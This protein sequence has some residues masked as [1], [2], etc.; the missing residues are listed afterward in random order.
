[1][2]RPSPDPKL[3][4]YHF[5]AYYLR[6]LRKKHQ[7]TQ[8]QVAEILHCSDSQISKYESGEKLLNGEECER[9]DE[10]W[11]TGKLFQIMLFFAKLGTDTSWPQRLARYQRTAIEHCVFGENVVPLPLQTEGYARSILE[12]GHAAGFLDDVD[13]ALAIRMERQRSMLEGDPEVWVI[14]DE[15][16]LRPMGPPQVMAEQ[17]DYLLEMGRQR[18]VSVRI[19]PKSAAPHIGVDGSFHVFTLRDNRR[20]AYSGNAINVGRVI[21]DQKEVASV[22]LR[23]QRLAARSLSEDQSRDL[24]AKMGEDS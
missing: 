10:T 4:L 18:N 12:A 23:F 15:V 3:S 1:M 13:I 24:I 17:R 20:A 19:L 14:I 22:A 21:D 2:V 5:M 9:L 6:F 16:A 8:R 7:L 11:Q